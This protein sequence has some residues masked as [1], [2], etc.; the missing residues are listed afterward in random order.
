MASVT[1]PPEWQ[2]FLAKHAEKDL[3]M[4][5]TPKPVIPLQSMPKAP[6]IT[7]V[8]AGKLFV[9]YIDNHPGIRQN[10]IWC[11]SARGW[12]ARSLLDNR[13]YWRSYS[14]WSTALKNELKATF[15]DHVLDPRKR[16]LSLDP[17]KTTFTFDEIRKVYL[18]LRS[19]LALS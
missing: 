8:A 3:R 9:S 6:K 15:T 2:Q 14:L 19:T 1:L 7:K 17:S 11:S 10:I 12:Q 4:P 13:K 5:D 18:S 16:L